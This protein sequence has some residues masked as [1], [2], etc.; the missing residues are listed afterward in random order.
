MVI[1]PR[2]V[3]LLSKS[4]NIFAYT[5]NA[6]MYITNVLISKLNFANAIFFY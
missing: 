6:N 5:S 1:L 2:I 3:S 4:I